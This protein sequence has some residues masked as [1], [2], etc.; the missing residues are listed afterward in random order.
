MKTIKIRIKIKT[1]FILGLIACIFM[2]PFF[3]QSFTYMML[4]KIYESFDEDKADAYYVRSITQKGLG[5]V[6]SAIS[7]ID[8][9]LGS[10][11]QYGAL[12]SASKGS[13]GS[14]A[15]YLEEDSLNQINEEHKK[16]L[17]RKKSDQ[18]GIYEMKIAMANFNS[19][20]KNFAFEILRNLNYIKD[21]K[22][23]ELKNLHLAAM[24]LMDGQNNIGIDILRHNTFDS[25]KTAADFLF[26][27]YYFITGNM[28]NYHKYK[29]EQQREPYYDL[30]KVNES[31]KDL[32]EPLFGFYELQREFD[33]IE[34]IKHSA[35]ESGN[36]VSG[37]IIL[38]SE[39]VPPVFI[40]L[41]PENGIDGWSS[42][43]IIGMDAVAAAVAD[44]AGHYRIGH[45]KNGRYRLYITTFANAVLGTS[46]SFN[47][48]DVIELNGNTEI[49]DENIYM[50]PLEIEAHA[51]KEGREISVSTQNVPKS[52]YYRM[53][54][55]HRVKTRSGSSTVILFESGKIQVPKTSFEMEDKVHLQA[56]RGHSSGSGPNPLSYLPPFYGEDEYIV[57]VTGYDRQHNILFSTDKMGEMNRYEDEHCS[58]TLKF[59]DANEADKKLRGGD[60]EGAIPLY[61]QYAKENDRYAIAILAELYMDGYIYD[62]TK[63]NWDDYGGKDFEKAAYYLEQLLKYDPD[64]KQIISELNRCYDKLEQYDKKRVLDSE[65]KDLDTIM[66]EI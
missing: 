15:V 7:R 61:E 45:I 47:E 29:W 53:F 38:P 58:T 64:N 4:G 28:D 43:Q 56:G 54:L 25:Y 66:G 63:D 14:S 40:S 23:I 51:V 18:L 20:N 26:S 9:I 10:Q 19:G 41:V 37:K 50:M 42:N 8:S 60:Y 59:T 55:K 30:G 3:M 65:D 31:Y 12:Y 46:L 52:D 22:L 49:K 5:S 33:R 62:S 24:H 39:Q 35:P 6:V 57:T 44:D 27:Y 36:S 16:V 11:F 48:S 34:K 17:G 2:L 21:K 32:V 1:L 13:R